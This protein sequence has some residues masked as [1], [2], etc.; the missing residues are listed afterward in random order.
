MGVPFS[1]VKTAGESSGSDR[2]SQDDG[3]ELLGAD[4]AKAV[5]FKEGWKLV[6]GAADARVVGLEE[7]DELGIFVGGLL[8][9]DDAKAVGFKEG[10]EL[11]LGAADAKELGM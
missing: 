6:L 1:T 2:A 4:D 9:A 3:A 8:G 10:W 7:G 11:V 5:G